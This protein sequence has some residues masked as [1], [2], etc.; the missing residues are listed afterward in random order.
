[1]KKILITFLAFAFA[2]TSCGWLSEAD[3]EYVSDYDSDDL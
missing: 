3:S 1:M 2:L